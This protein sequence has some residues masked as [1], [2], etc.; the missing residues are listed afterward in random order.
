[1][2]RQDLLGISYGV[3]NGGGAHEPQMELEHVEDLGATWA[4]VATGTTVGK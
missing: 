2:I 1:M 4:K 3:H